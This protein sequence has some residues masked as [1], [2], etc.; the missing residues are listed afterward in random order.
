MVGLSIEQIPWFEWE[1]PIPS[2]E[3]TNR[4]S[5]PAG[6]GLRAGTNVAI[7]HGIAMDQDPET[8]RKR[9][10]AAVALVIAPRGVEHDLLLVRRATYAGDPWSGHLALPGGRSERADATLE[11][12]ARRETL[13]E[14][15]VDLATASCIAQLPILT[16]RIVALPALTVH[17]FVFLHSGARDVTPSEEIDEAWWIPLRELGAHDAWRLTQITVN[18]EQRSVR[19]FPWRGAVIWGITERILDSFFSRPDLPELLGTRDRSGPGA[20]VEPTERAS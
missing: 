1:E 12:T 3:G 4:T 2:G 8:T 13:E 18:G 16:P 7:L 5:P 17:P 14:T 19:A 6:L 15:G 10:P 9:R 11:A 20:S